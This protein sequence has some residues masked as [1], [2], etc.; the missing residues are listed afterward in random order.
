MLH[1]TSFT[2]LLEHR[3]ILLLQG[4]MGPFFARLAAYLRGRGHD[5][6]KINFNG[7][8]EW[9]FPGPNACPAV[10]AGDSYGVW[11]REFIVAQQISAVVLFGQD[12]PV[13]RPVAALALELGVQLFVF[14]EGYVRP[15]YVTLEMGGVNGRSALPRERAFYDALPPAGPESTPRPRPVGASF[16]NMARQAIGYRFAMMLFSRR[17][18]KH[19]YHRTLGAWAEAAHWLRGSVRK[20]LNRS[21]DRAELRRLRDPLRSGRWFLMMLQVHNDSQI[22]SHSSYPGMEAAIDEV[23]TSFA[24]HAHPDEWLVIKHHPM[25][26][27]YRNFATHI[28]TTAR[29]LGVQG[30][31]RYVHDL[32]LPALLEHARGM[33]TVNSTTGLLAL[34]HHKPVFLLGES[35]YAVEGLVRSGSLDEFWRNPGSVDRALYQRFRCHL[36]LNTQLNASFYGDAPALYDGRP[37]DRRASDRGGSDRRAHERDALRPVSRHLNIWFALFLRELYARAHNSIFGYIWIVAEPALHVGVLLAVF[38]RHGHQLAGGATFA[39]FALLGVLGYRIFRQV[40]ERMMSVMDLYAPVF[41]Y[42]QVFPIDVLLIRFAYELLVVVVLFLMFVGIATFAYPGTIS[43]P[44]VPLALGAFAV[45]AMM[46][47]GLGMMAF[48]LRQVSPKISR[49]VP[50]LTRD[51]YFISGVFFSLSTL[52]SWAAKMLWWNPILQTIDMFREAILTGFSSPTSLGYVSLCGL[53]SVALGSSVYFAFR[54]Q[55]RG[56]V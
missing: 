6:L 43:F 5:V 35:F 33:V 17:F 2:A 47:M 34:R 21:E 1:P 39:P 23:M 9:Y 18:P 38:G 27:A 45:F 11:L 25:D 53:I 42:P 41:V 44:N 55:V 48:V 12:R 13:H 36:I 24:A 49:F 28:K 40:V 8:D 26:R 37:P 3:R 19:E 14:E 56:R 10:V 15:D 46:S 20:L 54:N 4:P 29:R 32:Y 51:L 22:V 16:F 7:G 30:R 50:A 31:V 52:P